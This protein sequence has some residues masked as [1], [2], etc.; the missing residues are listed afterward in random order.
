[1]S[2]STEEVLNYLKLARLNK[3]V[4]IWL[5]FW[6]F[7]WSGLMAARRESIP[8][9]SIIQPLLLYGLGS[10]FLRSAA[11][12]WNDLCDIDI[13][14]AV[15][16][17]KTRPLASGAVSPPGAYLY[18]AFL[19][20]ACLALLSL[21]SDTAWYQG[22]FGFFFLNSLYPLMKR[23][24]SWPQAWLGLA[25]NWGF[26]VVWMDLVVAQSGDLKFIICIMLALASWTI[27][28]DSIYACQDMADDA[29]L[30][31]KS[32]ALLFGPWIRPIL[33]L[34]ASLFTSL[35][36]ASGILN[37]QGPIFFM[38]SVGGASLHLS[39]QLFTLKISD[40]GDCQRKFLSNVKVGWIVAIG[41]WLDNYLTTYDYS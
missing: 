34:F 28:Y 21:T 14:R 15:E 7:A 10:V 26:I 8:A 31:V 39:W 17:T 30:G 24:T 22:L 16:R 1:M 18:L 20:A 12:V 40:P 11:C 27:F 19:S 23:V 41:L 32:T 13:D 38:F 25:I 9:S 4:G 6:P 5:F 3:P 36:A 2:Y 35:L 29:K 37:G 33:F